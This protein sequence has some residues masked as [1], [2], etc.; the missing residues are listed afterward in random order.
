M[1]RIRKKYGIA[2]ENEENESRIGAID[3]YA[4]IRTKY[5]S[6]LQIIE[7]YDKARAVAGERL[8]KE[9]QGYQK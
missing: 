7:Y 3:T 9:R 1:E 8:G 6:S 2:I 4:P 5:L